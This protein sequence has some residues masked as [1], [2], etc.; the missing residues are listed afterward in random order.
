MRLIMDSIKP[1]ISIFDEYE[2]P[3]FQHLL[4]IAE[5]S[6][7]KTLNIAGIMEKYH[8]EAKFLIIVLCDVKDNIE[9][10]F[11]MFPAKE[12][13]HVDRLKGQGIKPEGK[14][15][16]LYHPFSFN[17]PKNKKLPDINFYT[18]SLKELGRKEY[19]LLVESDWES[20]AVRMMLDASRSIDRNEG[21]LSF[22]QYLQNKT[23]RFV[24]KYKGKRIEGFNLKGLISDFGDMKSFKDILSYF[25]LFENDYFL[26]PDDFPLN[27]NFKEILEDQENLHIFF[28]KWIKDEKIKDFNTLAIFTQILKNIDYAKYPI[29]L[30]L[31]EI[32]MQTPY[33]PEGYKKFL[34]EATKDNLSIMRNKGRGCIMISDGQIWSKIDEDVRDSFV[35]TFL[36]K[37]G[38]FGDIEKIR[39]A[40]NYKRDI[41]DQLIRMEGR[42]TYILKGEEDI[43]TF[44]LD[45]SSAMNKEP[46]YNFFEMYE[47]NFP[48][49]MKNY[50][51]ITDQ[52]KSFKNN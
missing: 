11:Q 31:P 45:F 52:M 16:K 30:V 43:G 3:Y 27:L 12:K 32:R 19:G 5:S 34:A 37:I 7:G 29:L 21:L 40:L 42:N 26:A 9:Y 20:N 46:R 8:E 41:A 50:K 24:E 13:Y 25:S 18:L 39:K 49:K 14:K 2:R 1:G 36:G 15:V 4:L 51:D 17:I 47:K 48:E 22:Q 23:K 33:R 10:G 28:T 44:Q 35:T 38:G 6:W